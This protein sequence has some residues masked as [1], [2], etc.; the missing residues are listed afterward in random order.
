MNFFENKIITKMFGECNNDNAFAKFMYQLNI[1]GFIS[2]IALI[3]YDFY[4]MMT[5]TGFSF[6]NL[7]REI[8]FLLLIYGIIRVSYNKIWF[9]RR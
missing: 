6:L 4:F 5:T 9:Y 7:L 8:G 2:A 3:I 1:V